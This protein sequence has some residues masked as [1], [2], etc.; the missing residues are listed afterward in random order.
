MKKML[1]LGFL[2]TLA[3]VA[4]AQPLPPPNPTPIDGG[5]SLLLAA[6]GA[7]GYRT[8]KK[9]TQQKEESAD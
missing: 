3:E 6:G 4:M 1:V 2:M 5:L 7:L 9:H 8:Y